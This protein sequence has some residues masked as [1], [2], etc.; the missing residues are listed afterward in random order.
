MRGASAQVPRAIRQPTRV[1]LGLGAPIYV[2]PRSD[3]PVVPAPVFVSRNSP[4]ARRVTQI[5]PIYMSPLRSDL[6]VT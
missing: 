5:T 1:S 2:S 3:L 6:C 4:T